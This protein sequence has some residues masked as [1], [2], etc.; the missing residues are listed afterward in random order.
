MMNKRL[1]ILGALA[2]AFAGTTITAA[3]WWLRNNIETVV[4]EKTVEVAPEVEFSTIAVASQPLR[5]GEELSASVVKEIAWPQDALPEGSF[6]TTEDLLDD[7]RRIVLRPMAA[8]EPIL[9]TK[10]TGAGDKGGL[11]RL[12][13]P[14]TRAVTINVNMTTGV[15]G[16]VLPG[17]RVD[18]VL[19][20][21]TVLDPQN[22]ESNWL[23]PVDT[24]VRAEGTRV[25]VAT[26]ILADVRILTIDQVV[27]ETLSEPLAVATVTLALTPPQAKTVTAAASAGTLH[28]HLRGTGDS[29]VASQ[30]AV[31]IDPTP[32]AAFGQSSGAQSIP[33]NKVDVVVRHRDDARTVSVPAEGGAR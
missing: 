13:D 25:S 24:Q 12:L 21:F 14:G 5:Y 15:A 23:S 22:E 7:G 29:D 26:T 17:D 33:N 1:L 32:T 20:R 31:S 30:P 9:D 18:I 2:V 11:S 6:A 28:L 4:V 8:N 27:D 3:D 19:H 16:F 10:V